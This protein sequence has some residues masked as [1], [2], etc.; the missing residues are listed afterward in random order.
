MTARGKFMLA[1]DGQIVVTA[2]IGRQRA[3]PPVAL[4]ARRRRGRAPVT[5]GVVG[6]M[7]GRSDGPDRLLAGCCAKRCDDATRRTIWSRRVGV[8]C[9]RK[10]PDCDVE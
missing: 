6:E 3:V 8:R 10:D 2:N 5:S 7:V 1:A 9:E 4:L